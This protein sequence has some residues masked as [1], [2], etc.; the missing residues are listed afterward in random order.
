MKEKY[1]FTYGSLLLPFVMEE[2]VGFYKEPEKSAFIKGYKIIAQ[3]NKENG[4]NYLI[5]KKTN[6]EK[7]IIPGFLVKYND[8]QLKRLDRYEAKNYKRETVKVYTRNME[9]IEAFMYLNKE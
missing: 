5:A 6:N 9:L 4:Y 2:K 8:D 7:D 1:L 3:E